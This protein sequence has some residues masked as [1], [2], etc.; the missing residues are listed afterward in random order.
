MR[1]GA[2][3]GWLVI[4]GEGSD[5]ASERVGLVA[6]HSGDVLPQDEGWVNFVCEHGV[7]EGEVSTRV[8]E[9]LAQS[10]FG[11]GL[12]R[13]PTNEN[14][15]KV[16]VAPSV[17]LDHVAEVW[18]LR[19]VVSQDGAGELVDLRERNRLVIE[20]SPS[21]AGGLNSAAHRQESEWGFH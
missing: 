11:E 2:G 7:P 8:V 1:A 17:N 18:Y 15:D 10:G 12:A 16:T 14:I 6:E 19:V 21:C 20:L 4:P 13:C 9:S 3:L 5:E